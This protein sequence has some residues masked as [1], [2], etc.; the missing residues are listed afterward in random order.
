[1][2]YDIYIFYP[3]AIVLVVDLVNINVDVVDLVNVLVHP[4]FVFT[5]QYGSFACIGR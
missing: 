4:P 2:I 1:M 5:K 3:C